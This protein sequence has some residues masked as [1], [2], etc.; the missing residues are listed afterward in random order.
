MRKIHETGEIALNSQEVSLLTAALGV[1]VEFWKGH[2]GT[3]PEGRLKEVFKFN[4]ESYSKMS[5]DLEK[6][7]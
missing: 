3:A 4:E 5:G 2:A 7:S 6:I 1:T